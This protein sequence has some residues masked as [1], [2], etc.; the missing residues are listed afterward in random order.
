MFCGNE[1][2]YVDN[3]RD[4]KVTL[5]YIFCKKKKKIRN[6]RKRRRRRKEKKVDGRR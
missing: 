1:R 5:Y 2:Q 4:I 3:L 6:G